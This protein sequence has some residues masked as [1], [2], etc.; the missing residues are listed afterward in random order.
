MAGAHVEMTRHARML[1]EE[2][3]QH[4]DRLD[5]LLYERATYQG[6]GNG[7]R[8]HINFTTPLD[9]EDAVAQL[10]AAMK[11]AGFPSPKD[12]KNDSTKEPD[13]STPHN[14]NQP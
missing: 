9:S 7:G 2:L 8:Y 4:K 6:G 1:E 5:Y 11:V 3:Q 14:E 12:P 10:D 13:A